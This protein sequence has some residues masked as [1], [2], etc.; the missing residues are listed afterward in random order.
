MRVCDCCRPPL[1]W[2]RRTPYLWAIAPP[3][4]LGLVERLVLGTHAV[5]SWIGLRVV[6]V[7]SG[8]AASG[9]RATASIHAGSAAAA[10]QAPAPA[11]DPATWT[12]PHLWIG[13]I[14]A[15]IFF[16]ASVWLRRSREPL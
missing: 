7:F 1:P 12:G 3:L 2:A 13:L 16:A 15:V 11:P 8:A 9:A 14:L 5:W 6:G 10:I 4:L